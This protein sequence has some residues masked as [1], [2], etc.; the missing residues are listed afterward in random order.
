LHYISEQ[1][2]AE[3]PQNDPPQ[4][5]NEKVFRSSIARGHLVSPNPLGRLHGHRGVKLRGKVENLKTT[6]LGEAAQ[7]I[8]LRD[9][10]FSIYDYSNNNLEAQEAEHID[11]LGQL[12]DERGLI[13]HGEV[14]E[15]INS[16]RPR[17]GEEPN[18]WD[19][20]NKL[21]WRLQG[22]F[23]IPQLEGYIESFEGKREP[24]A[25]PAE[26]VAD[27]EEASIVRIT[28][29]Q[30]GVS[31]IRGRFD[32]DPLRGYFLKSHTEK[33]RIILRLLR[34]CWM[35]ELPELELGIGQFEIQLK[36]EDLGAL[37][38][39]CMRISGSKS[40]TDRLQLVLSPP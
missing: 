16:C 3:Q 24:E 34:E 33:Q 20:I 5:K 40:G 28:A 18:T 32:N 26:W 27:D 10:G 29:W 13:G 9:S 21:V 25:P 38:G 17:P 37:L 6:S 23:T 4:V 22:A 2:S 15:N 11:I 1:A 36:R 39:I 31:E 12:D 35:L 19:E 14:N 7:V 8:V 30:P